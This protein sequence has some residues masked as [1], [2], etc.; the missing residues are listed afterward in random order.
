M[1]CWVA[2][3]V[4]A[5]FWGVSIERVLEMMQTGSVPCKTE[6]GFSL[7]DISSGNTTQGV[8]DSAPPPPTYKQSATDEATVDTSDFTN[9]LIAAANI[10]L[11]VEEAATPALDFDW[12]RGRRVAS[13]TRRAPASALAL[14]A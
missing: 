3:S 6:L 12:R 14:A 1:S 4:A 13:L 8:R 2:P 10:P 7:L 5:E 11:P 9:L